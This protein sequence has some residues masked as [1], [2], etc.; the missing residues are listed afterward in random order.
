MGATKLYKPTERIMSMKKRIN[1][2]PDRS[3]P[4]L[5][6]T[7][8]PVGAIQDGRDKYATGAN[9]IKLPSQATTIGTWN[10]RTLYACGRLQELIHELKRYQWD[11][12]GLSE[13]RWTGFG[14]STT[15]DGHKMWY[16][17]DERK[18]QFGVAFLVRR[19]IAN[20]VLSSTPVSN[21]IITIRIAAKPH[22]MTIIQVYAPTS[23]YDDETVEK[24]YELLDATITKVPKKD[25][26][27]V[28]GDWNAKIG[29]DAYETWAGTTGKFSARVTNDCGLRLLEFAKSHRLTLANTL[30]PHKPSRTTTWHSPNGLVHNQIDFILTP[31]RFKSSINKAKTRT[32]PGADVGSDHDLVMTT[33]KLKLL[34][35]RTP[36]S[37]RIRF[38][39][40]KLKDPGI[41][42]VFQAQVGGKF[43]TL[44]AIDSD[45]NTLA[46]NMNEILVETAEKVLGKR[47]KKIQPWVTNEVLDL[48]D[49]RRELRGK[50]HSS[51]E[52]RRRYQEAHHEVRKK[53][54]ETKE[55]WVE[56]QCCEID[57]RTH[58]GDSN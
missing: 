18:H 4:G 33:I 53:M 56:E 57:R 19:E 16:S 48:C 40:E 49:R 17:G 44:A 35:K 28:Q 7:A 12:I 39:L 27:I 2:I 8:R 51:A 46:T 41:A 25:I 9:T 5:P 32:F 50:K 38:D 42:E 6:T 26:T 24:F 30:H 14:E 47:R 21:R 10:V 37:P 58:T 29:P 23:D 43:A 31:Q 1:T 13:V 52:D 55:A 11:I 36:Q 15:E 54:K 45:V 20:C 3:R 34:A 22:N